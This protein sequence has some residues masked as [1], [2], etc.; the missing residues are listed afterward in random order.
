MIEDTKRVIRRANNDVKRYTKNYI[1]S[2]TNLTKNRGELR[3]TGRVNSSCTTSGT[4]RATLVTNPV[5]SNEWGKLQ[6]FITTK[7]THPWSRETQICRYSLPG[8]VRHRYDVT[9]YQVMW[10]TDMTLQFTR[11]RETHIWRYSLP[12]HVRHRYADTV[13]QIMWDTD[14]PLQ[15]TRS[16]NIIFCVLSEN[17]NTSYKY[18]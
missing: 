15:F 14:M 9:V 1:S 11:S 10:D 2:N 12:G 17:D 13:Y 5:R 6:I 7:G 8:H 18:T 3:C 4:D 16:C